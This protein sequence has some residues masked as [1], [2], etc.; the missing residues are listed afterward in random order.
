M[1]LVKKIVG[2][3]FFKNWY[4]NLYIK[5]VACIAIIIVLTYIQIVL[6]KYEWGM[7]ITHSTIIGILLSS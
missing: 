5:S 6:L 1:V 3:S 7:A 2:D 4:D